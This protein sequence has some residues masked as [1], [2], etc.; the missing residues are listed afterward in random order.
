MVFSCIVALIQLDIFGCQQDFVHENSPIFYSGHNFS[1]SGLT[2]RNEAK[3]QYPKKFNKELYMQKYPCKQILSKYVHIILC[4]WKCIIENL[5]NVI[6]TKTWPFYEG[7][8][9]N[10]INSRLQRSSWKSKENMLN[11]H[12]T[13]QRQSY[14][15]KLFVSSLFYLSGQALLFHIVFVQ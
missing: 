6:R 3:S 8:S 11:Y 5:G 2:F 1:F 13:Q 15:S 4:V 9:L 7:K 10:L 12:F 14:H